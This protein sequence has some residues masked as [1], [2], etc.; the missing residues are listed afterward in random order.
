MDAE[1]VTEHDISRYIDARLAQGKRET[2]VNR[3]LQYLGQ[4]MRLTKRRKLL[5]DILSIEKCSEK[6]NA[7]QGLFETADFERLVSFLPEDLKDFVRFGYLRL[8]QGG[9][10]TTRMAICRE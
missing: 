9:S 1:Q 4:A 7:R 8:T 6:E 10:G 5:K 2:T 3:E